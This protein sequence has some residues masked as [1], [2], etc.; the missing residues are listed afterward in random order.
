M[1]KV[2]NLFG[3]TNIYDFA[4]K[5]GLPLVCEWNTETSKWEASF[6]GTL[7][8]DP[9]SDPYLMGKKGSGTNPDAAVQEYWTMIRGMTLV[10]EPFGGSKRRKE[11]QVV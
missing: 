10:L 11:I 5:S 6:A 1:S 3:S 7:V 4:R 9:A 2:L 8:R